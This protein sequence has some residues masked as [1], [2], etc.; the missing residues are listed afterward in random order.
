MIPQ[1][2]TI[3][4]MKKIYTIKSNAVFTRMYAKGKCEVLPTVVVYVRKNTRLENAQIGITTAKKLGG[5]VSRNRARRLI[6]ESWR[7]LTK[8]NEGLL[9]KPYY[10]VF[11]ARSKIFKKTC[12]MQS[13]KR[14]ILHALEKLGLIESEKEA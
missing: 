5:A 8:E 13:V 12:K 10:I 1:I 2:L 3:I 11:V 4:D 6:R 14:D 9:N 7:I